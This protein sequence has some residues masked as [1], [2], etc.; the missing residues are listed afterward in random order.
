ME[1]MIYAIVHPGDD[2]AFTSSISGNTLYVPTKGNDDLVRY[3][4]A[5]DAYDMGD[6]SIRTEKIPR[7]DPRYKNVART[8]SGNSSPPLTRTWV[9]VDEHTTNGSACTILSSASY[10]AGAV[11]TLGGADRYGGHTTAPA[12]NYVSACSRVHLEYPVNRLGETYASE[13]CCIEVGRAL[14]GAL[15]SN[16]ELKFPGATCGADE[17][18]DLKGETPYININENPFSTTILG[19][20]TNDNAQT[21]IPARLKITF[22]NGNRLYRIDD[23]ATIRRNLW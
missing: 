19:A 12:Y 15:T 2:G 14:S 5:R 22:R 4:S 8:G 6:C 11:S 23:D 3:Y 21:P 17:G 9:T 20:A 1:Q 13:K 16:C 18:F 10:V 7:Q